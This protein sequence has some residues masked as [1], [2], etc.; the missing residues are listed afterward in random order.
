MRLGSEF[1]C[2]VV[3]I[4]GSLASCFPLL[5]VLDLSDMSDSF[6]R[7]IGGKNTKVAC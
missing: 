5:A 2:A 7:I 6:H 1:C 3:N 4:V